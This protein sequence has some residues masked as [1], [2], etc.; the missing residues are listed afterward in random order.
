MKKRIISLMCTVVMIL[1]AIFVAPSSAFAEETYDFTDNYDT[2]TQGIEKVGEWEI[3]PNHSDFGLSVVGREQ[4][5]PKTALS[6][7][8]KAKK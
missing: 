5:I 1:S 4:P 6:T 2:W 3:F 8:L 7:R